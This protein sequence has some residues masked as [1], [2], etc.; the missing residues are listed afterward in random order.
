M[1]GTHLQGLRGGTGRGLLDS[2]EFPPLKALVR[3]LPTTRPTAEPMAMP[4]M[5]DAI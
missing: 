4:A 5:V 1:G 2:S 3:V